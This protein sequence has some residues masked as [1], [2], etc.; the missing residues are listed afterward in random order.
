MVFEIITR[1]SDGMIRYQRRCNCGWR[2]SS[3]AEI[4]PPRNISYNCPKCGKKNSGTV[5]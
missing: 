3:I 1:K 4:K 2:E 5:K